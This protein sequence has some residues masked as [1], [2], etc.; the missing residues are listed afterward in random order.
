M[1]VDIAFYLIW[2]TLFIPNMKRGI[3]DFMIIDFSNLLTFLIWYGITVAFL[4]LAYIY[5]KSVFALIPM[6]Y[7][8]IILGISTANY[9][10]IGDFLVHKVFN[11]AGLGISIVLYIVIDDIETRRKVISQVFK[12][13]YKNS[14]K[15][16]EEK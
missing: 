8:L 12:N 10:L 14:K 11:F 7:F 15:K 4:M 1:G 9:T 2:K 16:E 6:I 3:K 5:K 13:R